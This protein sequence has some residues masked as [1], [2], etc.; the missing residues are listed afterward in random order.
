M[1]YKTIIEYM[2][3]HDFLK[4]DQRKIFD[5]IE[6]HNRTTTKNFNFIDGYLTRKELVLTMRNG[7]TEEVSRLLLGIQENF[8]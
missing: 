2:K 7:S 4:A 1:N 3:K 6:Q 5:Y 8:I